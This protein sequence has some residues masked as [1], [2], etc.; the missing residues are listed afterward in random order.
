MMT[1]NLTANA[2]L[3]HYTTEEGV[4]GEQAFLEKRQP[5]FHNYSGCYR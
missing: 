4:E 2:T 3:L 5:N 1:I